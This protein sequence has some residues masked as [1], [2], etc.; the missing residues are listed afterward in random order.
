MS[1]SI[2]RGVALLPGEQPG[3]KIGAQAAMRMVVLNR[4]SLSG[5]RSRRPPNNALQNHPHAVWVLG[6]VVRDD[7]SQIRIGES[8]DLGVVQIG[9]RRGPVR[10]RKLVILGGR[11]SDLGASISGAPTGAESGRS[12]LPGTERAPLTAGSGSSSAG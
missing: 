2:D 8:A 3:L 1:P 7:R 5:L 12:G 4:I 6:G 11:G 9:M 10:D